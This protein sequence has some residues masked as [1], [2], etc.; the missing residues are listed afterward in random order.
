M[1]AITDQTIQT[2]T[3]LSIPQIQ[4]RARSD[5]LEQSG[6]SIFGQEI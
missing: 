6:N 4:R 1:N 5:V 2:T 3:I